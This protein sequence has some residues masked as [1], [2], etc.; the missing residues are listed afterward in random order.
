MGVGKRSQF[1]SYIVTAWT[2]ISSIQTAVQHLLSQHYM[3]CVYD[4][5]IDVFSTPKLCRTFYKQLF[6]LGMID[7]FWEIMTP[8]IFVSASNYLNCFDLI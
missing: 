1:N 3:I 5:E 7:E 4:I 8:V 6:T 2:S